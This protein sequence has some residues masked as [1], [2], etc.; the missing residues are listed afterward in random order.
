MRWSPV[1]RPEYGLKEIE[2]S[3]FEGRMPL[4][5]ANARLEVPILWTSDIRVNFAKRDSAPDPVKRR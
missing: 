2:K 1:V 5:E 4:Y 3:T